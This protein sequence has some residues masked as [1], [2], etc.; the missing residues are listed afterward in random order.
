MSQIILLVTVAIVLIV[1]GVIALML[2]LVIKSMLLRRRRD[3]GVLRALGFTNRQKTRQ[4]SLEYLPVVVMGLAAGTVIGYVA[5]P[6]LFGA[7]MRTTGVYKAFTSPSLGAATAVAA[8]LAAFAYLLA[9]VV[10]SRVR[11]I[12]VV[13]LISE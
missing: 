5:F 10:A 4:I 7:V 6:V 11:H 8:G 2:H 1:A 12:S 9:T 3:W 13:A